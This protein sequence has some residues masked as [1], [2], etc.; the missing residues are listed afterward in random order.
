MQLQQASQIAMIV[1]AA[2][3]G[4]AA[5]DAVE[6]ILAPVLL[7]FVTGIVLSPLFGAWDRL[8][9]RPAIGAL[10]AVL[11]IVAVVGAVGMAL[12]PVV[13]QLVDQAPK[14]MSDLDDAMETFRDLGRSLRQ[15]SD[16][17]NEAIAA[18]DPAEP[19]SAP[20]PAPPDEPVL[21]TVTDAILL[22]PA[23]LG[24]FLIFT[25]TLFFF[26][27]TRQEIYA[28]ISRHIAGGG[29]ADPAQITA[30]L[31]RAERLV[32]RYFLT[33]SLINAGLGAVSGLAF[34]VMGLPNAMLWGVIVALMNFIT[35]LGPAIATIGLL[36]AGIA[37]FDGPMALAPAVGFVVL[38]A[39]EGQF[40]TPGLVG[41]QVAVNPLLV[42]LALIF[43]VWL[44][45]P[46]GGFV[47]LPLVI[48]CLVLFDPQTLE[49][50][51]MAAAPS[52]GPGS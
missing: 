27:L 1:I 21:P 22:A 15:A 26:V 7:A 43:G 37:A 45:G 46:I 31:R 10:G 4:F 8:G 24:Q 13:G 30:R 40:A 29:A 48:W 17:V 3:L 5:L 35:Y 16:E 51:E 47:A 6:A 25:G 33:I 23:I 42:F 34:Q 28:W 44:W 14:V 49:L 12:Q 18:S 11:A 52:A 38:N 32:S 9:L 19:G 20:A 36:F 41:R 39:I 50:G 2:I